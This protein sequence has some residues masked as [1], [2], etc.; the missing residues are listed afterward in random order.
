M[1]A[2]AILAHVPGHTGDRLGKCDQQPC[3]TQQP[4]VINKGKKVA[5]E[6]E[7]DAGL[8]TV[9]AMPN[10]TSDYFN[11]VI[12]SDSKT[13]VTV[14]ILDVYGRVLLVRKSVDAN[15][16]LRFGENLYSGTYLVNVIKGKIEKTVKMIKIN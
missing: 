7:I 10:P 14:K 11:L 3:G 5:Q 16:T 9:A 4:L 15:T 2:N 8:F 12:K 6:T 13:L 1:P